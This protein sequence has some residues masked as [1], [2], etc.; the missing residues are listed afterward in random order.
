MNSPMKNLLFLLPLCL[1]SLSLFSQDAEVKKIR[2]LYYAYNEKIHEQGDE[3]SSNLPL[4]IVMQ[5]K[6]N[7]SPVGPVDKTVTM[8]YDYRDITLGAE[9]ILRKVI[10]TEVAV[11][12]NYIELF[13]DEQSQLIFS[14]LKHIGCHIPCGESRMYFSENKLIQVINTIN[15]DYGDDAACEGGTRKGS[16]LTKADIKNGNNNIKFA[17]KYLL[18]FST[19][20]NN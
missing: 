4:K 16:A 10:I 15:K 5:S 6:R 1:C 20:I 18:L 12:E 3:I 19:Y 14:Y 17:N 11:Y 13:F 2:E 7:V 8:Y 9:Y